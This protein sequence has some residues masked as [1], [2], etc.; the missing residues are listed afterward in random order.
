MTKM[1]SVLFSLLTACTYVTY[2]SSALCGDDADAPVVDSP[3]P[4]PTCRSVAIVG[5]SNAREDGRVSELTGAD[6]MYAD[7]FPGVRELVREGSGTAYPPTWSVDLD[8]PAVKPVV[9][10]GILR[11]GSEVVMARDLVAA[12]PGTTWRMI[13]ETIDSTSMWNIWRPSITTVTPNHFKIVHDD[14]VARSVDCPVAAYLFIQGESDATVLARANAYGGY[15]TDYVTA[16]RALLGDVPFVY[17]RL[18]A[19]TA[20]GYVAQ[21]RIGEASLSLPN[22]HMVDQDGFS[23]RSDNTHYLTSGVIGR[24]HLFSAEILSAVPNP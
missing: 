2:D 11:F 24:A 19:A 3:S 13:K 8:L 12:R 1:S 18:N 20:A 14:I 17:G 7:P 10:G 23:L 9:F 16:M 22:V 5:Q 15:L 21:L 4:P 6:L